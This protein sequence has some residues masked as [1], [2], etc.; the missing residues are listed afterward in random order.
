MLP[1]IRPRYSNSSSRVFGKPPTQFVRRVDV[2]PQE[3][4]VGGPLQRDD[5]QVLVVGHG[6]ADELHLEPRLAFEIQDLLARVADV[7]QRVARVVL[8]D[9]LARLRRDP[10]LEHA[11]PGLAGGRAD[12][13]R[14]GA[15]VG[16]QLHLLRA[17]DPPVVLD[18]DRD[19]LA[20]IAGLRDDRRRPA[21]TRLEHR[22][23]RA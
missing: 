21:A 10:E 23:R 17:D 8:R 20:R 14:R 16:R 4:V 2:E 6:A 3:L 19:C 18:V 5:L 9:D 13:H 15:A 11:R 22:A 12:A 7:D 1:R